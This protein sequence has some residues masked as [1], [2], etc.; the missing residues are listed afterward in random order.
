M[1]MC[2]CHEIHGISIIITIVTIKEEEFPFFFDIIHTCVNSV[3]ELNHTSWSIYMDG[4]VQ[5]IQS[6][7]IPYKISPVIFCL[8]IPQSLLRRTVHAPLKISIIYTRAYLFL[9]ISF[10]GVLYHFGAEIT[11][12]HLPL[13]P[14]PT[15]SQF[16]TF[17]ICSCISLISLGYFIR[18]LINHIVSLVFM[19][20]IL[21]LD[22]ANSLSTFSSVFSK[23]IKRQL[24]ILVYLFFLTQ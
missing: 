5:M 20:N 2:G 13:G 23:K 24:L 17:L 3:V 7:D 14:N 1:N 12:V 18:P 4:V 8:D 19:T 22:F 16:Q 11:L 21:A 6:H 10:S 9:Q 15:S